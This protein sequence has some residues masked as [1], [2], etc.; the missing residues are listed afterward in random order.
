M[1]ASRARM[2]QGK[3]E[4]AP[5]AAPSPSPAPKSSAVAPGQGSLTRNDSAALKKVLAPTKQSAPSPTPGN[6]NNFPAS[7]RTSL[8]IAP[9]SVATSLSPEMQAL[10]DEIL[11]EVRKELLLMKDEILAAINS[12]RGY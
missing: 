3:K 6:S 5:A 4:S 1:M 12:N 8:V 11:E 9:N 10:K 2:L 7:Q